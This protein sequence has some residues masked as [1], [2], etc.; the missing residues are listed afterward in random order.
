MAE[1]ERSE[2]QTE[3]LLSRF[4]DRYPVLEDFYPLASGVDRKLVEDFPRE[5]SWRVIAALRRHVLDPRYLRAV[6]DGEFRYS[7]DGQRQGPVSEEHREY[8]LMRLSEME[9]EQESGLSDQDLSRIVYKGARFVLLQQ[10][11]YVYGQRT[12]QQTAELMARPLEKRQVEHL[13]RQLMDGMDSDSWLGRVAE[14]TGARV[15]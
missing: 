13:A 15:S 4:R 1:T 11:D 2:T 7:L 8:A 9:Q 5:P 3:R 6:A 10:V 14:V 12:A